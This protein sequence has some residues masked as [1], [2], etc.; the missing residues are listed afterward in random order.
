MKE[1]Y[2]EG[3]ASHHGPGS[4]ADSREA[5]GGALIRARIGWVM[6]H[7]IAVGECRRRQGRRKAT[8]QH[9]AKRD[10]L[11]LPEVRDPMHVRNHRV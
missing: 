2:V 4:Y 10:A 9:V 7:E 3:R 8:P 11:G 1:P 5:V 6:S